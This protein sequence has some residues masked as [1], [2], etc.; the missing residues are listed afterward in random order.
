MSTLSV[1]VIPADE[2]EAARR[3]GHDAQ[4]HPIE[5]FTSE[6]GDQ[7]RC[8]LRLSTP[9][10]AV[11]LV[12][13]APL[14]VDRPWREVGPVFVHAEAC[15]GHDLDRLP[16]W[17]DEGPLVLR[18]YAADGSMA[19]AHHRLHDPGSDVNAAVA[20]M[21]AEPGVAEV[22]VRNRV[23]QCFVCRVTA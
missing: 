23:A 20:T 14:R 19:Y 5:P 8:C 11:A 10:E 12:S 4:G 6:G 3:T 17:L 7:L 22:H 9:G 15:R 18:A 13:Y 1:H 16:A 2:L 21:L